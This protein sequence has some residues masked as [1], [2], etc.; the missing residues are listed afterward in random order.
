MTYEGTLTL[1][2]SGEIVRQVRKTQTRHV[3]EFLIL[4]IMWRK[5]TIDY[6]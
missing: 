6:I 4:L 1:A 2:E 5:I 3:F